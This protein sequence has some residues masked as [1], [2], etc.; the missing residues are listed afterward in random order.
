MCHSDRNFGNE[1]RRLASVVKPGLAVRSHGVKPPTVHY[2][3]EDIMSQSPVIYQ[4]KTPNCGYMYN[5]EK[6]DKKG[7]IP[8]GTSFEDLPDDWKCP[9]CGATKKSFSL[10]SFPAS[11]QT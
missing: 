4:C 5:R 11:S 3:V 7:K 10:I 6:G 9:I 1:Y 2:Q 8:K